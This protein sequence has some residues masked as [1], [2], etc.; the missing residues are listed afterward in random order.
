MKYLV[1]VGVL[2]GCGGGV[3]DLDASA[4]GAC[5]NLALDACSANAAC[6]PAFLESPFG[7]P[8]RFAFLHC[9]ALEDRADAAATCPADHDACRAR[10]DCSPLFYQQL[11]EVDQAVGDP[12]FK[13]C[14][15]P[16]AIL[17]GN[18]P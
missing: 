4:Q 1:L 7:A 13:R 6:Q 12:T 9:L 5:S 10:R 16:D 2:S 18:N 11:G 17:A 8:Q 15:R 3:N 14:D